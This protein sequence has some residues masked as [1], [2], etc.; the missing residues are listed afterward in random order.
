MSS[1]V[2]FDK[3]SE[4]FAGSSR[5]MG[6]SEAEQ[7]RNK[8][9]FVLLIEEGFNRGNLAV[10][11]EIVADEMKEHQ[12][13]GPGHPDG[14]EGVKR[15]ITDCRRMFS[16]FTL[17]LDEVVAVGDKVWA[18]GMGGGTQDGEIMGRPATGRRA[19]VLT[20]EVARFE[21]GKMVEHWGVPD[22]FHMMIQVGL[23]PSG[24]DKP[25]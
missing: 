12:F 14:P 19:S 2:G 16:D 9:Q 24:P 4:Q 25:R 3:M 6:P 21:N 11:D 17:K 1:A 20:L 23:I 8:A 15:V 18:R 13:L 10:V 7:E 5:D 22:M